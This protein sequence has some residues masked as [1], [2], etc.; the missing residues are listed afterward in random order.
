LRLKSRGFIG[1][2]AHGV[3]I[4]TEILC[5]D[6][7]GIDRLR[8]LHPKGHWPQRREEQQRGARFRVS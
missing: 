1:D 7:V 3:Q 2:K 6:V 8:D 5:F 4:V